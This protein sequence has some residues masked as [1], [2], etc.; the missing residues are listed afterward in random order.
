MQNLTKEELIKE[1]REV[2]EAIPPAAFELDLRITIKTMQALAEGNPV[3]PAQLA[4]LWEMPL[5]QVQDILERAKA[6]GQVEVDDNGDL[7]GA[8]LS[9][10]PTSHQVMIDNKALYAWCAYDAIYAPQVVGKP[11]EIVSK[12]PLTGETI[13]IFITNAGIERVQPQS[14]VVSVVGAETNLLSG[15]DGPRC[16]Q[17]L[18]FASRASAE[19]WLQNTSKISIL[20]VAEV[21]ELIEQFQT[22]PARRLGLL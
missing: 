22:G 15:P 8:V 3:S 7:V 6:G 1:Y 2:Y 13:Q 17:M 18:F 21:N 11:A 4:D 10:N 12:D 5:E 20:T 16:T 14:T 19:K 9:L